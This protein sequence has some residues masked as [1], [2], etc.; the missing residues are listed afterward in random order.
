M[1]RKRL[2][3]YARNLTLG[4]VVVSERLWRD[5][6]SGDPTIVGRGL[7]FDDRICTVVGVMPTRFR[8]PEDAGYWRARRLATDR[9]GAL[10]R[11]AF[12]AVA[13]LRT[14]DISTASAQADTLSAAI[15]RDG[16]DRMSVT[17]IPLLEATAGG[18][19]SILMLLFASVAIVLLIACGNVANLL[20]ARSLDRARELSV[21]LALGATRWRLLR[22]LL[23]DCAVIA[24]GATV[25]GLGVAWML[26]Q[27]MPR[28]SVGIVPRL[29]E[30]GL[31]WRVVTFA[32]GAATLSLGVFGL[33]PA[34]RAMRWAEV[35]PLHLKGSGAARVRATSKVLIAVEV[36]AT[37]LL[38]AG[39]VLTLTNLYRL[40]AVEP[41]F[42]AK[43]ITVAT[44]RAFYTKDAGPARSQPFGQILEGLRGTP[45]ITGA[46]AMSTVPL[47][48]QLAAPVRVQPESERLGSDYGTT[49]GMRVVSPDAL[50]VLRV[51]LVRGRQ[52]TASDGDG[53]PLVA[54]VNLELAGRL[55]PSG[56]PLGQVIAVSGGQ[57]GDP[58]TYRVVGVAA[59]I[60][61]SIYRP[62]MPEV[63]VNWAQR[64]T[65]RMNL[66]VRSELNPLAVEAAIRTAVRR[67]APD[68][69]TTD[70]A[71]IGQLTDQATQYYRFSSVLL[72]FFG[73]C[74]WLLDGTGIFAVVMHAVARRTRELGIRVAMGARFG[75][76][77]GLFLRD[78]APAMV[79]GIGAGLLATYAC[80]GLARRLVVGIRQPDLSVSVLAA[81]ILCVIAALA[82]WW[83]LRRA[84]QIDP[85]VALREE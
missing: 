61:G 37:L 14:P 48:R 38:V 75:Q 12:D 18:Y 28:L 62:A 15:P 53:A 3:P 66:V 85:V 47:G 69:A 58:Q 71:T 55:W 20:F 76:L 54:I 35:S 59:N 70:V 29:D 77:A 63:Y 50:S 10:G 46:A 74:S 33:A 67:V 9:G 57:R 25:A 17:L 30:T 5:R 52:F 22:E 73:L 42:H 6:F 82:A 2:A 7:R 27:L 41:G 8:Y 60:R 45:G 83:P 31:D 40:Y 34:W 78:L 43:G 56:T 32:A 13:R 26:L 4:N 80:T 21:R 49:A 84:S 51:P 11:G 68:A 39:S 36:A 23:T 72:M 65:P 1:R 81:T 19:R 24:A 64:P 44:V 16:T 79:V